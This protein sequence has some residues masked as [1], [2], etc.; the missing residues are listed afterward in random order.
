MRLGINWLL[1][2]LMVVGLAANLQSEP[3][4]S[5]AIEAADSRDFLFQGEY[6][7]ELRTEEGRKPVS[8][9]VRALGEQQFEVIAYEGNFPPGPGWDGESP[10]V[11][12]VKG[13]REG[14]NLR[15][16]H[17]EDPYYAVVQPGFTSVYS[18]DDTRIGLLERT[19][20]KSPTL[21]KAPPKE[22][23]VLFDGGSLD[24]WQDGAAMTSDGL[25]KEGATSKVTFGDAYLHIEFR[26]PYMPQARGQ[27]RGNSGVYLQ[28]RYEVQVLD[29]FGLPPKNNHAGGL[30]GERAP[31]HNMSLP[32]LAWQ[33]YDIWFHA[34][35][36]DENG[37]KIANAQVT[38][39]H[40][41][42]VIHKGVAL[43]QGT[44]GGASRNEVAKGPLHLQDHGTPV[45][46]RNI[47]LVKGADRS[48]VRSLPQQ[49]W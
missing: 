47:W 1:S 29:S 48:G 3:V 46:Y 39:K 9:Q 28:H 8:I 33:T 11:V 42:V 14:W 25:L 24:A 27:G 34:P 22:A 40:N 26:C 35:E 18:E 20:R 13:K 16:E 19:V 30:Y 17:P 36:F 21:G 15:V 5:S 31:N 41:G 38:V 6:T 10:D 32:P 12:R 4:F 44:G 49:R 45:R 43:S 37:N 2:G 23:T 7:G